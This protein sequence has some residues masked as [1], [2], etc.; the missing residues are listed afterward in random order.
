MRGETSI[1]L[2][3]CAT[4]NGL[5][6][7]MVSRAFAKYQPFVDRVRSLI[8]MQAGETW[9]V[10][11]LAALNGQAGSELEKLVSLNCRRQAG[12]FFTNHLLADRLLK[13]AVFGD[14][15]V[16]Y[17][18][19]CGAGDL[20]LAAARVLGPRKTLRETERLWNQSLRG[21]DRV[22]HF[23]EAA[24]VRLLLQGRVFHSRSRL[25]ADFQ[26]GNISV[27]DAMKESALMALATHVV[28]N[29]PFVSRH[30]SGGC[31]WTSGKANMAAVFVEHAMEHMQL[32][33]QLFA[34]LPEVLRTGSRYAKWRALVSSKAVMVSCESAGLFPGSADVDVF[35]LRLTRGLP[36]QE[37]NAI[38][39]ESATMQTHR[40]RLADQFDVTVGPVV[41][42]RDPHKGKYHPFAHPRNVASWEVLPQIKGRRRWA[43]RLIK[44]PFVVLRRTSRPGDQYRATASVIL[45]SEPVAVENHLIVCAPKDGL[46]ATCHRL[47]RHLRSEVIN[48]HLDEQMRCRHLTVGAVREIPLPDDFDTHE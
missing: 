7:G 18:P 30:V 40:G 37:H 28:M 14:D 9:R 17:D 33:A 2:A 4:F 21:T 20:L 26:F 11:A 36:K 8:E 38:W 35:L 46:L 12:A 3:G 42:Y 1:E 27:N 39:S 16:I 19:A 13:G 45:C 24:R 32:G 44:P 10:N 15:S 31:E 48:K 25:R 6:T 5:H 34:I 22:P 41:P 23:V 43:G 29:P 47:M